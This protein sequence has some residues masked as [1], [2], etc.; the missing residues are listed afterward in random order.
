MSKIKEVIG[1][2]KITEVPQVPSFF[3]GIINLRGRIISIVDLRVKL[4][5]KSREWE[6]KKTCIII[7]ETDDLTIGA[8][9]DTVDEVMGVNEN[10][11]CDKLELST[12]IDRSFITGV[13][14][15][16]DD[17]V[18]LFLS[19]EKLFSRDELKI[20]SSKN[21]LFFVEEIYEL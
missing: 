16:G 12:N 2:N 19:L 5:Q 21:Q 15:T 18:V 1:Y 20:L 6:P 9:V 13:T 3:K 10:E 8:I 4:G 14:N 17:S 11:I 7:T